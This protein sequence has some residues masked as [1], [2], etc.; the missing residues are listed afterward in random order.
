MRFHP[1]S[2]ITLEQAVAAPSTE[3]DLQSFQFP[4]ILVHDPE[5]TISASAD[6]LLDTFFY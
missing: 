3:V 4:L 2:E 1:K 5:T 6:T